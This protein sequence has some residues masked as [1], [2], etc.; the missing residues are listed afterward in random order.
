MAADGT[1]MVVEMVVPP[2]SG[3]AWSEVIAASDLNML[4]N[5]GG[6]ERSEMEYQNLFEGAGLELT[7]I[8]P[9]DTPWS[10]V[11]GKRRPIL[12]ANP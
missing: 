10:V 8:I 2:Q 6:H 12:A 5:T 3:D 1:V 7:R 11:E 4:V 9:T